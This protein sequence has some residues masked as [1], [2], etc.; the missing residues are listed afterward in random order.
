MIW[1]TS[2]F[3]FFNP[4]VVM[5]HIICIVIVLLIGCFTANTQ[6]KAPEIKYGKE[7]LPNLLDNPEKYTSDQRRNIYSSYCYQFIMDKEKYKLVIDTMIAFGVK[8]N[9]SLLISDALRN[10][11]FIY[12]MQGQYNLSLKN[13][14]K[15]DKLLANFPQEKAINLK[16]IGVKHLFLGNIDSAEHYM[17]KAKD[18]IYP[19]GERSNFLDLFGRLGDVD[20]AQRRYQSAL[21]NYQKSLELRDVAPSKLP[22]IAI[23]EKI[24]NIYAI[25]EDY[26][27]SQEYYQSAID[28]SVENNFQNS[29]HRNLYSITKIKMLKGDYRSGID[30]LRKAALFFERKD[31]KK[32]EYLVYCALADSYLSIDNMV[33]AKPYINMA[34]EIAEDPSLDVDASRAQY[35]NAKHL[36]N[37]NQLSQAKAIYLKLLESDIDLDRTTTRANVL[38]NLNDIYK[39]Q[40]DWKKADAIKDQI[41]FL[42]KKKRAYDQKNIVYDLDNKYKTKIKNNQIQELS[43]ESE[44]QE[45]TIGKRNK[46]LMISGI[47]LLL[48]LFSILAFWRAFVAKKKA[49]EELENKNNELSIALDTNKMLIKEIHHRVKNNL[50]VVSSL[51]NIQSRFEKDDSVIKAINSGKYRVQSMSLLHQNLYVNEDLTSVK[52]KDYFADLIT[53]LVEGYPL[54]GKEVE[55]EMNIDDIELDV[56]AL[57][58]LGL[59]ANEL[60]TNSLK[61]A[62]KDKRELYKLDFSIISFDGKI[63]MISKDNGPGLPFEEIPKRSSSMGMQLI[64]SFAHKLNAKVEIDNFHGAE[65]K[66]TFERPKTKNQKTHAAS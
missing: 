33:K 38:D 64:Q 21:I 32:D 61:Y 5:R 58:P 40:N 44:V 9:D 16:N 23:Y 37:L 42:E 10:Q 30:T 14:H 41:V 2:Y 15:A 4:I 26:T 50:Q 51:L 25:L 8:I 35:L 36:H 63:R 43:A 54:Q 66:L 1:N 31:M 53:S 45:L 27:H 39:R 34:L 65:I 11:G 57:V 56:D 49:N 59:I 28:L 6:S 46:Q 20:V 47:S 29:Y 62:Y 24:G 13:L 52:I 22:V 60:V 18:G 3:E 55:I 19:H 48:A 17:L 12:E 7:S